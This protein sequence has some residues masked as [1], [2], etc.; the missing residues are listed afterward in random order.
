GLVQLWSTVIQSHFCCY[1]CGLQNQ[2]EHLTFSKAGVCVS[3]RRQRSTWAGDVLAPVESQQST[4]GHSNSGVVGAI[5][6]RI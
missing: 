4:S 3:A 6:H 2:T 1:K 5:A